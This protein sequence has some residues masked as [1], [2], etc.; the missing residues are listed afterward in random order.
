MNDFNIKKHGEN[1]IFN[2]KYSLPIRH[3]HTG[4]NDI[5]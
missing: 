2:K 4:L 5:S 3:V 1:N